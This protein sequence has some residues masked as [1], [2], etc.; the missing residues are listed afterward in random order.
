M[1]REL[2]KSVAELP[3]PLQDFLLADAKT[4]SA[5]LAVHVQ[6]RTILPDDLA[7]V[8]DNNLCT[9]SATIAH[10][11]ITS[12]NVD[13]FTVVVQRIKRGW[14]D[15]FPSLFYHVLHADRC[16]SMR[17]ID[18]HRY[19]RLLEEYSVGP[20]EYCQFF[21]KKEATLLQ[22]VRWRLDTRLIIKQKENATKK[23]ELVKR[24]SRLLQRY[25]Y[26]INQ[27][28]TLVEQSICLAREWVKY[29]ALRRNGRPLHQRLYRD[30][31]KH[32]RCGRLSATIAHEICTA[33]SA[34]YPGSAQPSF[35]LDGETM[36]HGFWMA[37]KASYMVA[38]PGVLQMSLWAIKE[39]R[40]DWL[41]AALCMLPP[42]RKAGSYGWR[43]E[44][45]CAGRRI[46]HAV[47]RFARQKVSLFLTAA[48]TLVVASGHGED[49][50]FDASH[51]NDTLIRNLKH[52]WGQQDAAAVLANLARG[53]AG[54]EP[55]MFE[56]VRHQAVESHRRIF[57]RFRESDVLI[58]G[59]KYTRVLARRLRKPILFAKEKK[60]CIALVIC[61]KRIG[62]PLDI[63]FLILKKFCC[64]RY[65]NKDKF[66]MAMSATYVNGEI[67]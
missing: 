5:A 17:L 14:D 58:K 47:A 29:V 4:R 43:E 26:T 50:L 23:A 40:K 8:F 48:C 2:V 46:A 11:A 44:G 19:C 30:A 56:L 45:N 57:Q 52:V 21:N 15:I 6:A 42:S 20:N 61:L 63:I 49:I 35:F 25:V 31:V 60:A 53:D 9:P 37:Y 22:S 62:I 51:E 24:A 38:W 54:A 27:E 32:G 16:R 7:W 33:Y 12:G 28:R 64:A 13:L 41:A 3:K 67:F 66:S 55:V 34:A 39:E 36:W 1:F 65:I 18:L 10:A 59:S